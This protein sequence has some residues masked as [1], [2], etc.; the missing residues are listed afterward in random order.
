MLRRVMQI[1]QTSSGFE[2]ILQQASHKSGDHV[3][4]QQENAVV[5]NGH[6]TK[7]NFPSCMSTWPRSEWK[8]FWMD[9]KGG[10]QKTV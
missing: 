1:Y 9:A 6:L 2:E 8:D 3:V 10:L 5:H 7:M 4:F